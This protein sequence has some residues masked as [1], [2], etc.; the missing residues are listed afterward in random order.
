LE[1]ALAASAKE[2]V[3]SAA[4]YIYGTYRSVNK[5]LS[6]TARVRV[7]GCTLALVALLCGSA[8][9]GQADGREEKRVTT[10]RGRVLNQ[11]TKEPVGH[12][13]VTTMGDTYAIRTDDRGQFELEIKEQHEQKPVQ[14]NIIGGPLGTP[15]VLLARSPAFLPLKRPAFAK[16]VK[17]GQAEATIYLVPEAFVSSRISLPERYQ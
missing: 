4:T 9:W 7:L 14:G 17:E 6:A 2:M 8:A 1:A 13:L 3:E 16:A 15:L 10:I 5:P 11:M 12:A